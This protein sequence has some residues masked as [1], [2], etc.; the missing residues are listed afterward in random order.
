MAAIAFQLNG[1]DVELTGISPT[2]TLLNWLRYDKGLTGTKEGCAEGDCGACTIAL[3]DQSGDWLPVCACIQLIGMVHGREIRT[4]EA[5]SAEGSLHPVQSAMADGHGTQCGFCTPGFVMSL[6]VAQQ[7]DAL[8]GREQV[9]DA[10]SGNLCRCTG[11]GPIIDAALG[12]DPTGSNSEA[13]D[14]VVSAPAQPLHYR[15]EAQQFWS[16]TTTD[17]LA[18]IIAE[19]PE[20][21]I[22][23]GATDIGLWVTKH[24]FNPDKIIYTGRVAYL[25]RIERRDGNLLIGAGATYREAAEALGELHPGLSPLI[26]RIGG[27]QV[28]AAGTIGGNIAN[29]SP[30]GDMPPALIA[31]GG[32]LH[33]RHGARRRTLPLEEYFLGYGQQDRAPGEFIEAVEIP[34]QSTPSSLRCYKIAKRHDQD[35]TAVLGCFSVDVADDA[36]TSARIAYGGMAATPKRAAAAEAALTGATWNRDSIGKAMAALADDFTPMSDHRASAQYRSRIARNL[37][38]KYFHDRSGIA[39]DLPSEPLAM[40]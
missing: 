39:P 25:R 26:R 17:G 29:G 7:N 12:L 20:A 36:V 40:S 5:L 13:P 33:L 19:N 24:A 18:D 15:S 1:Q 37:L 3:R 6:W 27:A 2:T 9:C 38:L 16:P 8:T 30:I 32:V 28:R 35:I 14:A 34:L 22:L 23:S 31:A 4:V 10:L 11:Y 21:T